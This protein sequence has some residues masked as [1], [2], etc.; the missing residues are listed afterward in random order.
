MKRSRF[1][2][3]PKQYKDLCIRIMA[4]DGWKCRSCR[5]RTGLSAHHI[6]F[7]SQGGGDYDWNMITLCSGQ[8][9]RFCHQAVHARKLLILPPTGAIDGDIDANGPV[10][11]ARI[12]GWRPGSTI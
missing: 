9:S 3:P 10:K 11:F 8:D 4:R 2:L 7:R 1:A 12:H 5:A 6:I